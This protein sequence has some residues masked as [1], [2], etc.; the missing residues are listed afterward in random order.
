MFRKSADVWI[1]RSGFAI[2]LALVGVLLYQ[3]VERNPYS[4][5]F[6]AVVDL[7]QSSYIENVEEK[8]LFEHAMR[9]LTARLDPHSAYIG[10]DSLQAME[11]TLDREYAGVGM[12]VDK[13]SLGGPLIV[14]SP[15]FDTPAYRGGV[16]SG[17]LILAIDGVSTL[18][19]P[20]ADAVMRI[21]GNPGDD[22]RLRLQHAGQQPEIEACLTR[23]RIAVPS[24]IGDSRR[25]DRSW[26]FRLHDEPRI[27]Y[28][29]LVSFSKHTVD[30]LQTVLAAGESVPFGA[31]ILDLRSNP[32][33]YF[34]AAVE[35]CDLLIDH[36]V[37]VTTRDRQGQVQK[38]FNASRSIGLPLHVP[39]AILVDRYSASSSEIVAAC[40]QD[41]E[42]AV[43]IGERTW[44]K[45]SV[46]T[47]FGLKNSGG[48]LK[49]TT[50]TYWRPSGAR[51]HRGQSEDESQSWGVTPSKG[52]QVSLSEEEQ[53]QL[54]ELRRW[55]DVP[56]S[57]HSQAARLRDGQLP[58]T[59]SA[60][61]D[62]PRNPMVDRVLQ[63]AVEYL[64]GKL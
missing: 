36:G 49:L 12:K 52:F 46:Q 25:P 16:R 28:L 31:I 35:V 38:Q 4:S 56:M 29:R 57:D 27:A 20:R 63:R 6:A 19:M 5:E 41:H 21:R 9:G 2:A 54:S 1:V 62:Q 59:D 44:G 13:R 15:F 45:G 48:A 61:N 50:S 43:V 37:I 32:G 47:I 30:E 7:V 55:R 18:G 33:G 40:L 22:V 26:D 23:E 17:D 8:E 64:Q 42:R 11:Q 60:P 10:A 24:L 58:V 39:I 3:Q 34:E 51:I 14:L 53:R